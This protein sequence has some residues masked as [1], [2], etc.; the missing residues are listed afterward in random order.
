M[1]IRGGLGAVLVVSV[2][3]DINYDINALKAFVVD[4]KKIKPDTWY[5]LKGE[6]VV[7]VKER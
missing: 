6:K 2:E 4:G 1:K 3:N 5:T 7:E